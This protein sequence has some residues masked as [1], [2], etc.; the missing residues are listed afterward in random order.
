MNSIKKLYLKL[1]DARN[2][3]RLKPKAKKQAELKTYFPE[4]NEKRKSKKV[5]VKENLCHLKKIQGNK[6]F[7]YA[8]RL[9]Y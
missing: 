5:M 9:R 7:L 2:V 1:M 4:Y 8:V 6:R 3:A